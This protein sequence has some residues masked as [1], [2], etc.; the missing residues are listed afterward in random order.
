MRAGLHACGI[1][2]VSYQSERVVCTVTYWERSVILL[3]C[4]SV[5]EEISTLRVSVILSTEGVVEIS[6]WFINTRLSSVGI[7]RVLGIAIS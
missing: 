7:G 4:E 6:L 2:I 3:T 5:A 1:V